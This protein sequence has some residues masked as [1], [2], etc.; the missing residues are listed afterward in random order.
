MN[1]ENVL[2][3]PPNKQKDVTTIQK[4][5]RFFESTTGRKTSQ[6]LIAGMACTFFVTIYGR[7]T[8][9][10]GFYIEKFLKMKS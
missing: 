3:F 6:L 2:Q 10:V 7:E 9:L 8:Y 1:S 4:L 5:M